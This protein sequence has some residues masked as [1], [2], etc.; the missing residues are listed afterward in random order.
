M[1]KAFLVTNILVKNL[2]IFTKV[3]RSSKTTQNS[4]LHLIVHEIMVTWK[5]AK[6]VLSIGKS[7]LQIFEIP[8]FCITTLL[9]NVQSTCNT[10]YEVFILIR[11]KIEH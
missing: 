8:N 6:Y 10:K 11:K 5:G 4:V 2:D 7:L 9:I 3:S 1:E